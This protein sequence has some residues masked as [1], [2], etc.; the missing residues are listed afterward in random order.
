MQALQLGD[1]APNFSINS[2]QGSINLHHYLGS[3]WGVLYSHPADYTPVC[4]TELGRTAQLQHEFDARNVKVLA[5]S[6]DAASSHL[7]WISDINETQNCTVQFPI[8][9]DEAKEVAIQYG[10]LHPNASVHAT[11]RSVFIIDPNKKV[12]L[13]MTYPMNVGRNFAEI[14]RVIDALQLADKETVSTPADWQL[15][16]PVIVPPSVPTDAASA[17]YGHRLTIVKPYLRYVQL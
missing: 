14:L 2:S 17:K 8:I 16:Q 1:I 7:S 13:T 6:I 10:M 15:G 5:L 12:R 3:S 9:A 4:T 11:V